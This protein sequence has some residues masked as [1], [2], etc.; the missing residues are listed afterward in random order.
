VQPH[1]YNEFKREMTRD[2]VAS[3]GNGWG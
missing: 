2:S 1:D 3:A